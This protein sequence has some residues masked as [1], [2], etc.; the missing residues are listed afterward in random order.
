MKN[1]IRVSLCSKLSLL[2]VPPLPLSLLLPPGQRVRAFR[3]SEAAPP[4]NREPTPVS[5]TPCFSKVHQPLH[6][7]V[8]CFNSFQGSDLFVHFFAPIFLPMAFFPLRPLRSFAAK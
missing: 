5:L 6:D 7:P 1:K 4:A 3:G 2:L 8:N